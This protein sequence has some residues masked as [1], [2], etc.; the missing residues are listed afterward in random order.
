MPFNYPIGSGGA[1]AKK[2]KPAAQT[3]E[4]EPE[5]GAMGEDGAQ[6]IGRAHV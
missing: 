5:E 6:E 2:S 4:A 1:P 3:M